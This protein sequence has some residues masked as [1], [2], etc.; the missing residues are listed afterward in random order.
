MATFP[1]K[2]GNHSSPSAPAQVTGE[3]GP[4]STGNGG[5]KT[6]LGVKAAGTKNTVGV[7]KNVNLS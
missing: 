4:V 7:D 6:S 5:I 2:K 1:P 3:R